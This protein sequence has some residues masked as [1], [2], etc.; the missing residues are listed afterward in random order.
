MNILNAKKKRR[1]RNGHCI[2]EFGPAMFLGIVG[3]FF[4]AMALLSLGVTFFS[5]YILNDLQV[6]QASLVSQDMAQSTNSPVL[7]IMKKWQARGIGR[8]VNPIETPTA[9][10]AYLQGPTYAD[11]TK[12]VYVTVTTTVKCRP[13]VSMPFYTGIPGIG[14]P[15]TFTVA[16]QAFC[17][18]PSFS[19]SSS[20]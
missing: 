7:N 17:E 9:K 4:P 8:F 5:C 10:L 16:S 13:F 3:F 18:H 15:V 19:A 20:S 6:N 2:A 12:D 11:G 14:A 1:T